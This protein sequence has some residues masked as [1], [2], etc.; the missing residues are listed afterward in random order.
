MREASVERG[1][2]FQIFN[3]LGVRE[4]DNALML[5]WRCSTFTST[6][7]GY[8]IRRLVHYIG[9]GDCEEV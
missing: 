5:S 2:L 8:H 1:L 3:L 7:K 4:M 6:N 9:D